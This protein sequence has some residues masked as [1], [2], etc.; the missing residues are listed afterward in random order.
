MLKGVFLKCIFLSEEKGERRSYRQSIKRITAGWREESSL[1]N[2]F[3]CCFMYYSKEHT[4]SK[5]VGVT[6]QEIR[7]NTGKSEHRRCKEKQLQK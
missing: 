3:I 6:N 7:G 4:C 5:E 2:S 1:I